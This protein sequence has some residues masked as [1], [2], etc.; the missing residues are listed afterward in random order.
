MNIGYYRYKIK[1]LLNFET[2]QFF[3]NGLPFATATVI[4]RNYTSECKYLKYLDNSGRFRFFVFNNKW[5][6]NNSVKSLGE[7]ENYITSILTAQSDSRNIGN[8]VNSKVEIFADDISKDERL[9][10][11]EMFVSPRV[12]MYVGDGTTDYLKD[13]ILVSISGDGLKRDANE[14]TTTK[15]ILTLP[16]QYAITSF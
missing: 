13:W 2:V 4:A 9:K 6:Q 14:F 3:N 16:R 12:L 1:P 5:T 11:S 7:T 10:L 15:F 8:D